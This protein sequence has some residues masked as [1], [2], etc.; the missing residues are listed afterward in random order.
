MTDTNKCGNGIVCFFLLLQYKPS[1]CLSHAPMSGDIC[2]CII[3]NNLHNNY[4]K[5][6]S[7]LTYWISKLNIYLAFLWLLLKRNNGVSKWCK[8]CE[9]QSLTRTGRCNWKFQ[10]WTKMDQFKSLTS[11]NSNSKCSRGAV[12]EFGCSRVLQKHRWKIKNWCS[13]CG[14]EVYE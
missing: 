1:P 12:G 9:N 6:S 4:L 11:T 10:R 5:W 14:S 8:C 7:L 2:V 13:G 3:H